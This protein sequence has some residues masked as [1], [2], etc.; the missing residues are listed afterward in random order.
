MK[1][2]QAS[3]DEKS[4]VLQTLSIEDGI[5]LRVGVTLQSTEAC[6]LP[7]APE[8]LASR[9]YNLLKERRSTEVF[10]IG[11]GSKQNLSGK[12]T[13]LISRRDSKPLKFSLYELTL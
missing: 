12:Q 1:V 10:A 5:S 11:I 4:E 7:I 6:L 8:H 13:F 2:S 3:S 9:W